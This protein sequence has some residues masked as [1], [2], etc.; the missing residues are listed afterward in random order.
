[1]A[2]FNG[3]TRSWSVDVEPGDGSADN[4]TRYYP[5]VKIKDVLSTGAGER[6]VTSGAASYVAVRNEANVA[7]ISKT[8]AV[9]INTGVTGD[10]HLLGLFLTTALTGTCTISGFGDSDG[11]A[12]T[13]TLPAGTTAGH[14][15]FLASLNSAAPLVITCS[16]AADDNVVLVFW[17]PATL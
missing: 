12:Q 14:K 3:Y 8:T 6:L 4:P 7:V 15:D 5:L 2:E 11:T 16:N 17:K 9:T 10:T 13:I 1:M